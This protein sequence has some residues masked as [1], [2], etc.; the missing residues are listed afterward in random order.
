M[1]G[2]WCIPRFSSCF[3]YFA[4]T[5]RGLCNVMKALGTLP[6]MSQSCNCIVSAQRLLSTD[7]ES[8]YQHGVFWKYYFLA[9][10]AFIVTFV[11]WYLVN[12]Q[13]ASLS[14]DE[15]NVHVQLIPL[16]ITGL[17]EQG[18]TG[19]NR[20]SFLSKLS[21]ITR[22]NRQLLLWVHSVS[23]NCKWK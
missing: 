12:N 20:G 23:L 8:S 18:T 16:F 11:S 15:T 17:L 9:F 10:H 2:K 13:E 4:P 6:L 19:R 1:S 7:L 14:G 3:L 22:W 5:L 21:V